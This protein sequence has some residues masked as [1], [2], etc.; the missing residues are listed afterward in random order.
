M[1]VYTNNFLG[2]DIGATGIRLVQLLR[3]KNTFDLIAAGSLPNTV[4]PF[5][6]DDPQKKS[7]LVATLQQ[8][9]KDTAVKTRFTAIALPERH[10]HTHFFE[11]PTMS[12][13]KIEQ[14]I[15][16]EA[17]S[18]IPVPLEDVEMDWHIIEKYPK[19]NTL[20]VFLSAAPKLKVQTLLSIVEM[21]GLNPVVIENS[22][23]A[24]VRS[25]CT[26]PETENCL[27]FTLGA[28][29]SELAIVHEGI[30]KETRNVPMGGDTLTGNLISQ[31]G[32]EWDLADKAKL[33]YD[34]IKDE[35]G[36]QIKR[37]IEEFLAGLADEIKRSLQYYKEKRED[38]VITHA[39]FCGR[40]V[41][42]P[43]F[44]AM[45]QSKF[46]DL[47]IV[48]GDAWA[49]VNKSQD[50]IRNSRGIEHSFTLALGL[51]MRQL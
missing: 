21:A 6:T 3:R 5:T 51:A 27:V 16:W 30:I 22:L 12:P 2:L 10:V 50:I 24:T 38:V 25:T 28:L 9:I 48:T 1:S 40:S 13:E 29:N 41:L 47:T 20:G 32:L 35:V 44:Q 4:D 8:L 43:D 15:R 36:R 17:E 49:T 7:Q 45:M 14:T 23:V 18:I 31:L 33:N 46:S 39:I 11:F 19:K 26:T 34:K 37:I 42:L